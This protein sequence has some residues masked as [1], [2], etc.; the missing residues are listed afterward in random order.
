MLI[1]MAHNVDESVVLA[2]SRHAVTLTSFCYTP[3]KDDDDET[4]NHAANYP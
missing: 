4:R 2:F 1:D 3:Y